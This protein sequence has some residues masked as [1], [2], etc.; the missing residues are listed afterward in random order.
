MPLILSEPELSLSAPPA[1]NSDA[2]RAIFCHRYTDGRWVARAISALFGACVACPL[3][4]FRS[5]LGVLAWLA[6]ALT[7]ALLHLRT[8]HTAFDLVVGRDGVELRHTLLPRFIPWSMVLW[9]ERHDRQFVLRLRDERRE[10]CAC[11]IEDPSVLGIVC[12]SLERALNG[13]RAAQGATAPI[14]ALHR[15]ERSIA[16]WREHLAAL[17]RPSPYRA[18]QLNLLHVERVLA[19]PTLP[20]EQ[21][22]G[23]AI[24]LAHTDERGRARVAEEAERSADPHMHAALAD[25]ALGGFEEALIE[26]ALLP[27]IALMDD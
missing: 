1:L 7:A 5:L 24:A 20:A 16:Q 11:R 23:A 8:M 3:L 21:R 18:A 26:P 6:V 15:G 12:T 19:N 27:H 25:L 4:C 22:L 2:P 13:Y 14:D 9:L 17:A 10:T